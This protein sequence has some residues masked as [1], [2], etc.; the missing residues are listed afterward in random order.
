M[1]TSVP[2]ALEPPL[3][4][5]P[6]IGSA[7]FINDVEDWTLPEEVAQGLNRNVNRL[8]DPHQVPEPTSLGIPEG[9]AGLATRIVEPSVWAEPPT[10]FRS[11]N[12]DDAV[13]H[14]EAD[15]SSDEPET[16]IP[17]PRR[18]PVVEPPPVSRNP[19][20]VRWRD[21][22][23]SDDPSF[24]TPREE[25]ETLEHVLLQATPLTE[26]SETP[27]EELSL[28]ESSLVASTPVETPR[29]EL[30]TLA[31]RLVFPT[32]TTETPLETPLDE[33]Q[34]LDQFLL[35]GGST[36]DTPLRERG[37]LTRESTMTE[38]AWSQG[39]PNSSPLRHAT[40]ATLT[41]ESYFPSQP[42]SSPGRQISQA[43]TQE[44]LDAS[45]EYVYFHF[46]FVVTYQS[47][48]WINR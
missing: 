41:G 26:S 38:A 15:Y 36:G 44:T 37:N 40:S 30:D 1:A 35:T 32:P 11:E 33:L 14:L 12:A 20:R 17:P 47:T 24:E 16:S 8:P 23:P 9:V 29:E 21:H 19:S 42:I 4:A 28:L 2:V 43:A 39:F 46:K 18:E 3:D 27:R 7:E 13:S 5:G 25:L 10:P 22:Y 45:S 48:V 31:R 6:R 34:T